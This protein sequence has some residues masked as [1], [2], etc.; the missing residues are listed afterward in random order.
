MKKF[1]IILLLLIGGISAQAQTTFTK[2]VNGNL[3][4]KTEVKAK[5]PAKDTGMKVTIKEI[6]YPVYQGSK[7]GYYILRISKKSGK[8]YK[9]YIKIEG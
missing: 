2:D 5:E 6:E 7:G 3:V 9:S 8:E 1:I 4:P